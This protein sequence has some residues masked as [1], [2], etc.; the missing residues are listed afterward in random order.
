MGVERGG[1][2]DNAR[3]IIEFKIQNAEF[4]MQNSKCEINIENQED[5]EK[6]ISNFEWSGDV[7]CIVYT[8]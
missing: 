8:E 1:R 6:D 7:V 3:G 4:K 2:R 5:Y